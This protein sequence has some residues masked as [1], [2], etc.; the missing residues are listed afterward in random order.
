[1]AVKCR[2]KY[3]DLRRIPNLGELTYH[4]LECRPEIHEKFCNVVLER[5]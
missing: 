2:D 1:M 5:D 3:F 4:T